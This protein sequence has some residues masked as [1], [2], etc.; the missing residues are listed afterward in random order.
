MLILQDVAMTQA[1]PPLLTI[2]PFGL[3]STCPI[4][5][6][7]NLSVMS[8]NLLEGICRWI[9]LPDFPTLYRFMT[10]PRGVAQAGST[11]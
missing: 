5:D 4:K 1:K 6:A 3:W 8:D 2:W 7:G 10:I 9:L 11:Q